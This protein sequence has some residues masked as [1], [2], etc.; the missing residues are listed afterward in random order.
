M[1]VHAC[2]WHGS[3]QIVLASLYLSIVIWCL[4][5]TLY[6]DVPTSVAST[7]LQQLANSYRALFKE[8]SGVAYKPTTQSSLMCL[9]IEGG[10]SVVVLTT[11]I[12]NIKDLLIS[13]HQFLQQ[14][15]G[16]YFYIYIYK[17]HASQHT[18]ITGFFASKWLSIHH[19]FSLKSCLNSFTTK[20]MVI[21][22]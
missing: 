5:V 13:V 21:F 16:G 14:I 11:S 10:K 17:K 6:P 7:C 15:R 3:V 1:T 2:T 4:S 18:T 8:K 9:N 20:V 12:A 22:Q 19:L